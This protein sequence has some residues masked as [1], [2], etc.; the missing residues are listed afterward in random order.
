METTEKITLQ[1]F[2]EI[3]SA[4]NEHIP[5][6]DAERFLKEW[7]AAISE[8]LLETGQVEVND[9]GV[10]RLMRVRENETEKFISEGKEQLPIY[11]QI[12]FAPDEVLRKAINIPFAHFEPT[13]LNE[14]VVLPDIPEIAVGEAE[15][16]MPERNIVRRT[17]YMPKQEMHPAE[18]LDEEEPF[19]TFEHPDEEIPVITE[20][21]HDFY[22]HVTPHPSPHSQMKKHKKTSSVWVP[23]LG[24]VAIALAVLFFFN[25]VAIRKSEDDS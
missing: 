3:L 12:R 16:E 19:E 5:K 22:E 24:G 15:E 4:K 17:I 6:D 23:V 11:Y 18:N 25:A 2:I 1:N 9:F 7:I 8:S 10:F 20:A 13:L 21:I 14:G